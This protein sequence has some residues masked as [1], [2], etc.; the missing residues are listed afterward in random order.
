MK[1]ILQKLVFIAIFVNITTQHISAQVTC[2]AGYT[3]AGINFD[4]HY[5]GTIPPASPI[6]YAFGKNSMRFGWSGTN[7]FRGVS[8]LHSG[9]IGSFGGGADLK[10]DVTTGT[11]TLVFDD[12]VTNLKFSVYDIDNRHRITVTAKN[13]SNVSQTITM[14]KLSG[15]NLSIVG[16]GTTSAYATTTSTTNIANTSTDGTANITI[17][18]PVKTVIIAITKTSGSTSDSLY[19][20]D[21]TACNNN[22]VTGV[23]ATNYQAISTPELGQPSYI[24]ASYGDSIVIVNMANN[25]VELIYEVGNTNLIDTLFAPA[26]NSLAY[27]PKN[28]IVY[29]CDN[30][31]SPRNKSIYKYN[32]LTGVKSTFVTDVTTLGIPVFGNGVGSGGASFYDGALYIGQDMLAKDEPASVFRIDIDSITGIAIGK[33]SRVWSKLGNSGSSLYDWADFV[34][35]NGIFY[36]FNSSPGRAANTGLEHIN[37]N[38]DSTVAGYSLTSTIVNGSQ[39]GIDYKGN[40]YH[41]NGTN[42]SLY[43]PLAGTI[44][45]TTS[46]TGT[47]TISLTDAAESFKYPYDYGDAPLGY[48]IAFH[49]F[50]V[51]PKLMIGSTVDYEQLNSSNI[52]ADADDAYDTGSKN[53][54]DG[55]TTFPILA[56]TFSSYTV[57][58]RTTNNTGAMATLYGFIDFNRDGDFND[59]G[60]RS[61]PANVPN[62]TTITTPIA[63]NFVGLSGGSIGSSYIRFRIASNSIE[64]SNRNGYAESGEVEDYPIG[65]S[66]TALP[67]ELIEFKAE[68]LEKNTS[69]LTWSTASEFNNEYFEVQRK[70]GDNWFALGR[71]SGI[72][73]SST[74]N[75]YSFKDET[76]EN[77]INYYQLKQV[78]FDGKTEYSP[79][80]SVTFELKTKPI[81]N[82]ISLY[83]NPTN[84]DIWIKSNQEIDADNIL[85]IEVYNILGE[86]VHNTKMEN[87]LEKIS[88]S[89]YQNGLYFIK[90]GNETYRILKQ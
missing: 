87:I 48:G 10:F 11:D 70:K 50:R 60:E 22:A 72:G 19:I 29:F 57:N 83:P 52:T 8:A 76:A 66:A 58:V 17:N 86:I 62:G 78:D 77:G 36:N 13:A 30:A 35:N 24:M 53:D 84:N 79:M 68:A 89:E 5:F 80:V 45:G 37:L 69:L 49:K 1:P 56:V 18:G 75:R 43:N 39:S 85:N 31:R 73:F 3:K 27:D 51:A 9:S 2:G 15:T 44:G 16:T 81:S 65:I 61:L 71:V 55:V 6:Y 67:V 64:A 46:F 32:V 82:L 59:A 41:I 90:I 21:I 47:G 4:M 63:V 12:E 38:L 20:S 26:I 42:Y 40:I 74:L 33:A 34:I 14:T 28:Q 25:T 23:F 7:T 88:L 54:E